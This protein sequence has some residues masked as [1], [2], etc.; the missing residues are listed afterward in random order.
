MSS[1]TSRFS[2]KSTTP[3]HEFTTARVRRDHILIAK[4]KDWIKQTGSC[5]R[6]EGPLDKLMPEAMGTLPRLAMEQRGV[7]FLLACWPCN[8]CFDAPLTPHRL[9]NVIKKDI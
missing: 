8:V 6:C 7:P 3:G 4:E 5:P 1:G 2:R 9:D